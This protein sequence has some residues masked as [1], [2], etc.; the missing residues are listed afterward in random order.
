MKAQSS[1][2][3][4]PNEPPLLRADRGGIAVLTLNRPKSRN[5]L[6]EAMLAAVAGELTAIAQ[7]GTVR[8]VVVTGKGPA[9]SGGHDLKELTAR[10]SDPDHGR[11]YFQHIMATCSSM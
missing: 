11:G 2:R 10:R 9:F 3:V 1:V 8:A 6:S 7:D 5:A 4:S